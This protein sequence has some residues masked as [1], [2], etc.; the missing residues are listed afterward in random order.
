MD[1]KEEEGA[2]TSTSGIQV[3]LRIRPSSNPST[4]IQRD[5]ID[6]NKIL[7]Q[8]PK[9]EDEIVNNSK[10]SYSFQFNGI[11]DEKAKQ[12]DVFRT[13]GLPVIKNAL[14]GYN[15]TIFAVCRRCFYV[16]A[17]VLTT[18]WYFFNI[19]SRWNS[20]MGKPDLEKHSQLQAHPRGM[21]TEA[22]S[23][24]PSLTCSKQSKETEPMER[25][26]PATSH[27]LRY[28]IKV[29][30]ICLQSMAAVVLK[31]FQK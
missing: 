7:F 12:K 18:H 22:Y 30:M 27:T 15:S 5:D 21:T 23:Q 28:T 14:A 19:H 26:I 16:Y 24:G 6:V 4:H 8:V 20:S 11:L 1:I 29:D 10:S 31:I 25:L 13:I 9:Q 3:Y 2:D 17:N